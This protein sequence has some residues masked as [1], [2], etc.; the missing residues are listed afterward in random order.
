MLP[1]ITDGEDPTTRFNVMDDV[2]GWRKPTL[3]PEATEKL[4]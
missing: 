2:L 4:F 3:E 1:S